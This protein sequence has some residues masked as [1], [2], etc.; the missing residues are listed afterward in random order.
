[1]LPVMKRFSLCLL[2]ALYEP[3]K[4]FLRLPV[5]V[6]KVGIEPAACEKICV[7]NPAVLFQI[8]QVPPPE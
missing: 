8:V 5:N 1:M 2:H 6:G 4:A 7:C 3:F